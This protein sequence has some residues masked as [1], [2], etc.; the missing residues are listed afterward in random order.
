MQ[1]IHLDC[2]GLRD[3]RLDARNLPNPIY[4]D[5][6]DFII[7]LEQTLSQQIYELQEKQLSF[8]ERLILALASNSKLIRFR[9]N[10]NNFYYSCNYDWDEIATNIIKLANKIVA[11]MGNDEKSSHKTKL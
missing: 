6:E 9:E 5:G 10:P 4:I 8:K 11:E 7:R 2:S 3:I 1:Q